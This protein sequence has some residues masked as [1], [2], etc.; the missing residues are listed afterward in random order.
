MPIAAL[1]IL[2]AALLVLRRSIKRAPVGCQICLGYFSCR[3]CVIQGTD[4]CPLVNGG[5]P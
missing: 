3:Q 1:S 2:L 4:L 5:A